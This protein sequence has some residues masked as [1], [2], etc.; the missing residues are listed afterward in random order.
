MIKPCFS[1]LFGD[2]HQFKDQWSRCWCGQRSYPSRRGKSDIHYIKDEGSLDYGANT[3]DSG[4][5][6]SELHTE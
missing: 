4:E 2:V 3:A 5:V 6:G 1:S